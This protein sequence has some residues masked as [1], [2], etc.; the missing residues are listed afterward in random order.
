MTLLSNIILYKV[1]RNSEHSLNLQV[2]ND[3]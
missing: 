3:R 1:Q 2:H